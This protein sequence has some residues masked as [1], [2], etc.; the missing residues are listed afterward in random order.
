MAY[1]KVCELDWAL[2]GR[3]CTATSDQKVL[4]FNVLMPP[5]L[6]S[7]NISQRPNNKHTLEKWRTGLF[8]LLQHHECYSKLG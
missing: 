2:I 1:A 6:I 4:R 7:I 3:L 5:A 8:R